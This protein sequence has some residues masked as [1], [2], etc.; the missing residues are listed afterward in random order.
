MTATKPPRSIP[1][2]AAPLQRIRLGVLRA[3]VPRLYGQTLGL[4]TLLVLFGLMMVLSSSSIDSYAQTGSFFNTFQKQAL[5]AMLGYS[6]MLAIS[7]QRPET[8]QRFTNLFFV[9]AL[10]LQLMTVFVGR[11]VNGNRNWL[12]IGP[13]QIQPSELL[14]VALVLWMAREL[15]SLGDRTASLR[16]L[17]WPLGV[18]MAAALGLVLLGGDLGTTVIMS[19]ICFGA[20][21][22]GRVPWKYLIALGVVAAGGAMVFAMGGHSRASRIGAWLKG[23]SC[24]DYTTSCWQSMHG[25]WA[26]ANGGWFGVGL[27]NSKS[28]WAWLPEAG[29]DFIFAVI[30]EELGLVGAL[31]LIGLFVA[32]AVLTVRAVMRTDDVYAIVVLVG[33]MVWTVG[34]ALVNIAVVL[35]LLPVLGVPLPLVSS[36]GSALVA[37]LV[38]LGAMLSVMRKEPQPR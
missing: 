23:G 17:R 35:G 38:M 11:S 32:L 22:A 20:L 3:P 9:G 34:Q 8:L 15:Q 14:K 31:A 25:K 7:R 10:L 6:A 16:A 33:G 4:V 18:G 29:N 28:K 12:V 19:M 13:V 26:L 36:G 30:G 5:Y 2:P 27:G 1:E 21:V 24:D 37:N